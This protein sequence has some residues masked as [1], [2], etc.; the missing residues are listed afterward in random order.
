MRLNRAITTLLRLKENE[1]IVGL[2]GNF[3]F[4]IPEFYIFEPQG[5]FCGLDSA[6]ACD[7]SVDIVT[8]QVLVAI[9]E[10]LLDIDAIPENWTGNIPLDPAKYPALS[11]TV[12]IDKA[13]IAMIRS[14]LRAVRGMVLL[15][16]GYDFEADYLAVSN[17]W[18]T[19]ATMEN[20]L[21]SMP[22][23]GLVR[24][25]DKMSVAK[26]EFRAA[27]Q[28]LQK[29][30]AAIVARSDNL[31]HFLEYDEND[32]QDIGEARIVLGKAIASLDNVE[33]VDATYF[34]TQ[35]KL[36]K[37]PIAPDALPN[38]FVRQVYFGALFAG[39]VTRSLLPSFEYGSEYGT[40]AVNLLPVYFDTLPDS[41]FGGLAPDLTIDEIITTYTG[42]KWWTAAGYMRDKPV[43][44]LSNGKC[45][46]VSGTAAR[47]DAVTFKANVPGMWQVMR[48]DEGTVWRGVSGGMINSGAQASFPVPAGEKYRLEFLPSVTLDPA[49]SPITILALPEPLDDGGPYKETVDDVEWTFTIV[50][51]KAR[52]SSGTIDANTEGAVTI[53]GSL[54]GRPVVA[55]G[56]TAFAMRD[57]LTSI[58]VAETVSAIET[59][60]FFGCS[61]D[62]IVFLGDCP[63]FID[64]NAFYYLN[65]SCAFYA[66]R[67]KDWSGVTIP[68]TWQGHDISYVAGY[69]A[70][71]VVTPS[72][73]G[74]DFSVS[75][76]IELEVAEGHTIHYT[77]DGTEPTKESSSYAGPIAINSTCT[78]KFFAVNNETG[79]WGPVGA[80]SFNRVPSE[81]P[82]V[83]V[84]P[85][86]P[87]G[88]RFV[89]SQY[90]SLNA[91]S[92]KTIYYTT[93]GYDPMTSPTR[94]QY[95]GSIYMS[96]T[97]TLKYYAVDNA[98]G[99][100]SQVQT[101]KYTRRNADGGY[102]T[103]AVKGITWYY[104][105]YNGAAYLGKN[106][107]TATSPS[108]SNLA[109]SSSSILT[110]AVA[111]PE[112]LGGCPVVGI[113]AYAFFGCSVL[114]SVTIPDSV[115]SI[116]DWAFYCCSGLTS[117]TIPDSVTYIGS[118]A[119][120]CCSGL[121]SVTIPDSVT[122][123][124][125]CAFNMGGFSPSNLSSI[126]MEGGAAIIGEDAFKY[127]P[128]TC[129]VYVHKGSTGW[130][131]PIPGTWNEI[132]I[133]YIE[134]AV[135]PKIVGNIIWSYQ[136]VDGGVRLVH[137][138]DLGV[139]DLAE[140]HVDIPSTVNGSPVTKIGKG[141][142]KG[143]EKVT[144]VTIPAS[145]D[146]IEASA[147]RECTRLESVSLPEGLKE[148]GDSAFRECASLKSVTIPASVTNIGY[149]AFRDCLRLETVT[150]LGDPQPHHD[151]GAFMGVPS[152]TV[153]SGHTGYVT[154]IIYATVTNATE[155]ITVPEG[156]LAE[157][158]L[159]HTKTPSGAE[160][161]QAA[162]EERFGSDLSEA[163]KAPTGKKDLHGNA[164]YVWQDYVAGTDPL[165]EEDK[166]T[167]IIKMVDGVPVVEY[168]P[169]LSDGKAELRKYTTYGA[170]AIGEGW[171][172]VS[173]LSDE[174]RR[175]AGYQFFQVT[176]E[177]K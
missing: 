154:A 149:F 68:G 121:T 47:D 12:Y 101:A 51:G 152:F 39:N 173:N 58:S 55:I 111:L 122:S 177:M 140:G 130:G 70:R 5:E 132:Q 66:T 26:E 43:M 73:Q 75:T 166:F 88:T 30:D 105:I 85:S 19:C 174:A 31:T 131:V 61:A 135:F 151:L 33:T 71:I 15:I 29:A 62:S 59:M 125:D 77:L 1:T 95:T 141:A 69:D 176:V 106:S 139:A 17:A 92:G 118:F 23:V 163:L 153:I 42:N 4:S 53:P 14:A 20:L 136:F 82:A 34:A 134:D 150:L 148:I 93:D 142:F 79:D 67:A 54:G 32:A 171:D 107:P 13:E 27:F 18:V 21:A 81:N 28:W 89:G 94:I 116:G 164:L 147:F 46:A 109:V 156:W 16:Q 175:D 99:D 8:A 83:V 103:E 159:M 115:T 110:G 158:A 168:S 112:E 123:I 145:V 143:A 74:G 76:S 104:Y 64:G 129:T 40:D 80:V 117:V 114:T 146:A 86:V 48:C 44:K 160:S 90:V 170:K 24:N 84:T 2:L 98:Y 128:A 127:V 38:G 120:S 155:E 3:G 108:S 137:P 9:D 49:M 72:T 6:P 7:E 144:S 37:H 36:N 11:E 78:V 97:T 167:A 119:F 113:S 102:Y 165:D 126:I 162:F 52:L 57:K 169:K 25:L 35:S 172:D 41:T 161:Y 96:G 63:P 124:G 60:A 50:D 91:G 87:D 133:R 10:A 65:P 56:D 100:W 22:K 138:G 157:I 45:L